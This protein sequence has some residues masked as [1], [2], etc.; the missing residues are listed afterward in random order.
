MVLAVSGYGLSALYTLFGWRVVL[1]VVAVPIVAALIELFI[2]SPISPM[3]S[4]QDDTAKKGTAR[5]PH[6]PSDPV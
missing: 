1:T 3:T 6:P 5:S 4:P 2:G